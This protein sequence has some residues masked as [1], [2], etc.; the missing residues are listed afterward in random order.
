[1]AR[2]YNRDNINYSGLIGQ[3]IQNANQTSQLYANK[4][5]PWNTMGQGVGQVG[6]KL[7]EAGW[8][9]WSSQQNDARAQAIQ[10]RQFEQQEKL[11]R[12]QEEFQREQA[13]QN[14]GR[15][16]ILND[17]NAKNA[18]ELAKIQKEAQAE[19]DK[20]LARTKWTNLII[21]AEKFEQNGDPSS[22]AKMRN[23][24]ALL[25]KKWGFG[26]A[27]EN[28]VDL[29]RVE[30][31][32]KN[33]N[34]VL[35]PSTQEVTSTEVKSETVPSKPSEQSD[36]KLFQMKKYATVKEIGEKEKED[37]LGWAKNQ[38]PSADLQKIIDNVES[39]TPREV[40]WRKRLNKINED[41]KKY[42]MLTSAEKKE[43]EELTAKLAK[44]G[45]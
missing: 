23:E 21:D 36:K 39:L 11:Q 8:N 38:E 19:Y 18:L 5:Q 31:E 29:P 7:Q 37:V 9:E 14:F 24:A 33:V 35:E 40:T 41:E 3:A 22:A 13:A 1:M 20:D 16:L 17:I 2:I 4:Y 30:T 43:R 12:A 26:Q 32:N 10:Q 25:E 28:K 27:D 34:D 42:G 6:N 15:Q 45:K 44:A